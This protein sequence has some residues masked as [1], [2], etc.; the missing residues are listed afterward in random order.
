MAEDVTV[1][2]DGLVHLIR[3]AT[4]DRGARVV[5]VAC[6]REVAKGRTQDR[7]TFATLWGTEVTCT[8]STQGDNVPSCRDN[9]IPWSET[10]DPLKKKK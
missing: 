1:K 2:P 5:V 8:A 6:G 4:T 3:F 9:P 10:P 7:L